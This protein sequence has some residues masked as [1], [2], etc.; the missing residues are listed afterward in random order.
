[1]SKTL[2]FPRPQRGFTIVEIMVALVISLIL[3]AGVSQIFLANRETYRMQ[4]GLARVQENARFT[5]DQL[6]N[7]IS[8]AGFPEIIGGPLALAG[9]NGTSIS[10]RTQA[11]DCLG[12]ATGG[13]VVV[14]TYTLAGTSLTCSNDGVSQI[15]VDG[16]QA[17]NFSY[18]IDLD[19]KADRAAERYTIPTTVADL[20]KVVSVRLTL[21]ASDPALGITRTYVTTI[22]LRNAPVPSTL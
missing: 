10:V 19:K 5:I 12:D 7:E 17:L 6:R 14:N 2:S 4:A 21:T 13:A 8:M 15:L 1:M 22:P 11:A 20:E 18:G 16:I 3:L 9:T